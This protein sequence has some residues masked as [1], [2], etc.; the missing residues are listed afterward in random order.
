MC[1]ADFENFCLFEVNVGY[2]ICIRGTCY[3]VAVQSHF[4]LFCLRAG[5]QLAC[6]SSCLLAWWK[7]VLGIWHCYVIIIT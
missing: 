4:Q 1:I 5:L 3:G 2:K 7:Y 6:A